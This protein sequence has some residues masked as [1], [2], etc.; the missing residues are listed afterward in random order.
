MAKV[1]FTY[2]TAVKEKSIPDLNIPRIVDGLCI[3]FNYPEQIKSKDANGVEIMIP[4]PQTRQQFAIE[5]IMDNITNLMLQADA[6]KVE[7]DALETAKN[8]YVPPIVS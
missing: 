3:L 2:K 7:R 1:S 5:R 4:N 8:N 6:T